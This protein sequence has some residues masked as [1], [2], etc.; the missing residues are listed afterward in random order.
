MSNRGSTE[1]HSG[2]Q[3]PENKRTSL[4]LYT[5]AKEAYETWRA[6]SNNV[7]LL[8]VRTPE[9]YVFVGHADMA[10]KVPVAH[11]SYTWDQSRGLF[12]MRPLSDFVSRV[13]KIAAPD[14]QILA[15]CRSGGRSAMAVNLLAAAGFSRVYQIIDGMEGDAV[16]DPESVFRGQRLRNGWKNSGCPWTYNL[17]RER[18]L[19]PPEQS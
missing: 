8:D 13:R 1:S 18:L 14:D 5:T 3:V 15:M 7:R 6:D 11:Q 10:W 12:P 9:E 16:A 2:S 4:G 19:L 17:T